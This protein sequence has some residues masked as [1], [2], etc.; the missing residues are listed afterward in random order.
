MT[1]PVIVKECADSKFIL[2]PDDAAL[3]ADGADSTRI[4][5]RVTDEFG[6][7]RP[8]ANDAI[9]LEIDGPG[10]IVG[11]NPFSLIGGTGAVWIRAQEKAGRVRLKA[12]H[13]RLGK[14]QVEIEIIESPREMV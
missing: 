7:I 6:A 10:E 11:D 4:I 9:Q 8:F 2:V 14:Q 12:L 1:V 13:P 3:I 5:L